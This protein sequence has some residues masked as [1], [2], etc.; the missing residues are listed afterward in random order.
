[1]AST[2]IPIL[3]GKR[4]A[5]GVTGSIAVYKAVDLA[6]KL[7]QAG[8]IVDVVMTDAARR[9]VTPLTFQAVTGRGVYTSMWEAPDSQAGAPGGLPTHIAHVG[10]AEA[11][12]IVMIAPATADTLARLAHGRSDDLIG[13]TCLAAR[14]PVVVAPAMDGGM[15]EHPATRANLEIL[16]ARGAYL[17]EPETG[18]FASGLTGRGRLPETPALI[19]HLRLALGRDGVLSGRHLIVTAGATREALDPVRFITNHSSGRQGHAIAQAALDLGAS[20]TLVT[21]ARDLAAPVGVERVDVDSARDLLDAV[22]RRIG[23]SSPDGLIMSAA[24][25]DYRPATAADRKIKKSDDPNVGMTVELARNPDILMEIK[26]LRE[27]TGR[28][29]VVVGFAAETDDLLENAASKLRRKGMDLIVANDVSASDAGFRAD[30]NRVIMLD[31]EG[32]QTEID[33]TSKSR[34]AEIVIG[35]V[36]EL[37]DL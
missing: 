21:M 20:V 36:V 16:Q 13:V 14:C 24:V 33:L 28:P 6:S 29:L 11:A 3:D 26:A 25:S 31:R 9:F 5:L 7:T 8:A 22:S 32:G 34:I 37:L 19:G 15:Y 4:I 17:I 23:P 1:M 27:S 2:S 12:D 35:R 30:T 10:L 18:R